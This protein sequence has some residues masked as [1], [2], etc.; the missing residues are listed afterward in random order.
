[1]RL[2][3]LASDGLTVGGL[4]LL[5]DLAGGAVVGGHEEGVAGARA[6]RS[7]RAPAPDATGPPPCTL[8][9]CSSSMARTRP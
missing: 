7:G 2:R 9:P 4:A 8:L 6:P 3:A 1:M 5:G